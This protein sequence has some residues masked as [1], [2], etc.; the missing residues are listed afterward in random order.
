MYS[1]YCL[2]PKNPSK[3]SVFLRFVKVKFCMHCIFSCLSNL[4]HHS[5][6]CSVT[7]RISS[8]EITGPL[9]TA[10]AKIIPSL[11][12]NVKKKK[13]K[14]LKDWFYCANPIWWWEV[15]LFPVC[16]VF[17]TWLF[18][19]IQ[20]FSVITVWFNK[21][22]LDSIWAACLYV[23]QQPQNIFCICAVRSGSWLT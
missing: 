13:K 23:I 20:L 11:P 22:L 21:L 14:N 19:G 10:F 12:R 5:L 1:A 15:H 18:T 7:Q 16:I 9:A 17:L 8:H 3:C 6:L 4:T 2:F